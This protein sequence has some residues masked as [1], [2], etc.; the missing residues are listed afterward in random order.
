[1]VDH[2]MILDIVPTLARLLFSNRIKIR[3]SALQICILIAIGLQMKD[4]DTI[5]SELDLP[6]NQV[7]AFFNKT[8]R[9]ISASIANILEDDAEKSLSTSRVGISNTERIAANMNSLSTSL[10]ADQEEDEIDHIFNE[11]LKHSK[12]IPSSVSVPK[13]KVTSTNVDDNIVDKSNS[14]G[15]STSKKKDKSSKSNKK[16]RD[17]SDSNNNDCGSTTNTTKEEKKKKKKSKTRE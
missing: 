12:I 1:M 11:A 2:H 16:K 7:L 13:S 14:D 8:M 15:R 17:H 5:S 3:L 6:S 10:D 4:V 9:K